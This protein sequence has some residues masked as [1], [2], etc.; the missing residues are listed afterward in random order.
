M[1][2]LFSGCGVYHDHGNLAISRKQHKFPDVCLKSGEPTTNRLTLN[3]RMLQRSA[4]E[5]ASGGEISIEYAI[6]EQ[7]AGE[8]LNLNIPVGQAWLKANGFC[9]TRSKKAW[10]VT[11][12]GLGLLFLGIL[13]TVITPWLGVICVVG[14]GF[15]IYGFFVGGVNVKDF[16]FRIIQVDPQ[17]IWL[18]GVNEDIA[19]RFEPI[20]NAVGKK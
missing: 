19:R 16:P 17:F 8:Q 12:T 5:G 2:V 6:F 11:G 15:C 3:R 10:F 20:S 7:L 1:E 14:I 13:L 4:P 18:T 9:A